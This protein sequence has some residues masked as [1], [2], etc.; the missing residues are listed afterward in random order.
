MA[1]KKRKRPQKDPFTNPVDK[2]DTPGYKPD[3]TIE[4]VLMDTAERALTFLPAVKA[5]QGAQ[6]LRNILPQLRRKALPSASKKG[7]DPKTGSQLI[8]PVIQAGEMLADYLDLSQYTEQQQKAIQEER[9]VPEPMYHIGKEKPYY[10]KKFQPFK[11]FS[12]NT[13]NLDDEGYRQAMANVDKLTHDKKFFNNIEP[14]PDAIPPTTAAPRFEKYVAG[15]ERSLETQRLLDTI[16]FKTIN[17]QITG[18]RE[19]QQLLKKAM[20]NLSMEPGQDK[21]LPTLRFNKVGALNYDIRKISPDDK[22]LNKMQWLAK[23]ALQPGRP[24]GNKRWDR[25]V[26][27]NYLQKLA[28]LTDTQEKYEKNM[29]KYEKDILGRVVP[30]SYKRKPDHWNNSDWTHYQKNFPEFWQEKKGVMQKVFARVMQGKTMTG[31]AYWGPSLHSSNKAAQEARIHPLALD[32]REQ[33]SERWRAGP[34]NPAP[35]VFENRGT[36]TYYPPKKEP[37]SQHRPV[38]Y[39]H[40]WDFLAD[41]HRTL[42]KFLNSALSIDKDE[43]KAGINT[44]KWMDLGQRDD[45]VEFLSNISF[46]TFYSDTYYIPYKPSSRNA[47]WEEPVRYSANE[48]RKYF[49]NPPQLGSVDLL[50]PSETIRGRTTRDITRGIHLMVNEYAYIQETF[51]KDNAGFIE[52]WIGGKI[53]G[54]DPHVNPIFNNGTTLPDI[55]TYPQL[56]DVAQKIHKITIDDIK[57]P[58]EQFNQ[59]LPKKEQIKLSAIDIDFMKTSQLANLMLMYGKVEDAEDYGDNESIKGSQPKFKS[60]HKYTLISPFLRSRYPMYRISPSK[61]AKIDKALLKDP[62]RADQRTAWVTPDFRFGNLITSKITD[63]PISK[64]VKNL[65]KYTAV[66][67]KMFTRR[68]IERFVSNLAHQHP[69]IGEDSTST[70]SHMLMNGLLPHWETWETGKTEISGPRDKQSENDFKIQQTMKFLGFAGSH[71]RDEAGISTAVIDT[72]KIKDPNAKTQKFSDKRNIYRASVPASILALM[73]GAY[74][75]KKQMDEIERLKR[76]GRG[77]L[78]PKKRTRKGKRTRYENSN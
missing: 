35:S 1:D 45:I 40:S 76:E 47:K 12:F 29:F 74:L 57:E 24:G 22:L 37:T 7:V 56:L 71:T 60:L 43:E 54:R 6:Y 70:K 48:I 13:N 75:T 44:A 50:A 72:S 52:A 2:V 49:K 11:T 25:S 73:T 68:S 18:R 15:R 30:Y 5:A 9:T 32:L 46:P 63:I 33:W 34:K 78:R 77:E 66:K 62:G 26:V 41:N 59:T 31:S 8:P 65:N 36:T 20:D 69:D 10:T 58:L 38:A 67:N 3:T 28:D 19:Y 51:N 55:I 16:Y 14:D 27:E 64:L 4:G 21:F 39:E 23:S 17:P 42:K 61:S 53:N